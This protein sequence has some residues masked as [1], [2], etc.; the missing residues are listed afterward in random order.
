MGQQH[1]LL[2]FLFS[3]RRFG[4]KPGLERIDALLEYL[5]HPERKF[6]VVHVAGTNG[7]GSTCAYLESLFRHSGART[8]LYT[9]PHLVAPEERVRVDFRK[10]PRE[11]LLEL[12]RSLKPQ[13]ERVEA[14]FF[15]AMTAVAFAYFATEDVDVAIVE[16]GLGGRWDAT[17]VVR[18]SL[19]LITDVHLDHQV[20]LGRSV[21]EIAAEKAGILKE[22]VPCFT[23]VRS[24]A[25][26]AT[27]RRIGTEVGAE[28][29]RLQEEAR[30]RVNAV[31]T[32]GTGFSYRGGELRLSGVWTHLI[33]R[34]QARNAGLALFAHWAAGEQWLLPPDATATAVASTRWEGRFQIIRREP[35]RIVDVAHNVQGVRAFVETFRELWPAERAATVAVG[36]LRDKPFASM[37]RHLREIADRMVVCPLPT[38]RS[39]DAVELAGIAR[40][41]G[42]EV[43]SADSPTEAWRVAE[44]VAAERPV[45]A[46]GSHYLVGAVLEELGLAPE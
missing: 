43:R 13:I 29:H 8:G 1:P 41:L 46:I 42:F 3:R 7:K 35:L 23:Y 16:V 33:G 4:L 32:E 26:L 27:I 40:S 38:L 10:V 36:V 14:T 15:E 30:V 34:H 9:S 25:A 39:A 19:T 18:P 45:L 17:N 22:G 21:S 6:Q 12:I 11:A 31:T 20:H 2:D 5:G 24:N 28:V 44:D 37:A